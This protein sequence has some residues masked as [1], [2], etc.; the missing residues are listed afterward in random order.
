MARYHFVTEL[1]VRSAVDDV[2]GLLVE[3]EGWLDAWPDALHVERTC[4]GDPDGRGRAFDATVRAP[5]GYRLSARVTTVAVDRPTRLDM[6]TSGDLQ[7]RGRWDLVE[8]DGVT[9]VRFDWDVRTR[10]VWMDVLTPVLRPVFE[11][12]HHLVVR[13]AAEAAA[14]SLDAD[15]LQARS[16][17]VR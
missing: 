3:P 4:T 6:V 15:L 10:P 13:N 8:R 14:A 12:S 16:R 9:D 11:R 5:V 17:A 7:G 2:Y 1:R